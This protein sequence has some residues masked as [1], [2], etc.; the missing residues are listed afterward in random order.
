VTF[1]EAD[2]TRNIGTFDR[3]ARAF[4]VAPLL[5]AVGLI[6]GAGT[7]LG[8][9]FFVLAAVPLVTAAVGFCPLYALLHLTTRGATSQTH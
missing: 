9:V 7:T 5:V 6:A 3:K 8:V 4:G 1:E 2:M